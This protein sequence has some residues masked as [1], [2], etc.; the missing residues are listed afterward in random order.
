MRY[1]VCGL[2]NANGRRTFANQALGPS[3]RFLLRSPV[4]VPLS[5]VFQ[6]CDLFKHFYITAYCVFML[7][8]DS[9]F[10]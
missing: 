3:K 6:F 10:A 2:L 9:A 8:F 4:E 1:N 7:Q 5:Q